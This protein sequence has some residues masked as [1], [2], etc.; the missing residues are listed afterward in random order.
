MTGEPEGRF[1]PRVPP[2]TGL[3][4]RDPSSPKFPRS[5]A[6]KLAGLG[7]T[8]VLVAAAVIVLTQPSGSPPPSGCDLCGGG[9]AIGNPNLGV[10]GVG[11]FGHL[12]GCSSGDY[13]YTLTVESSQVTF[14]S[15]TFRTLTSAGTV[16]STPNGTPGF[17]ILNTS[18]S[19]VAQWTSTNGSMFMSA[20]GWTY[21]AGVSSSTPLTNLYSV[22]IDMGKADPMGQ[23]YTCVMV[24]VGAYSGTT[25]PLALP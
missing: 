20:V 23:G 7:V 17:A 3:G 14:G 24:G 12:S 22:V 5:L 15:V 2:P 11:G 25:S 18:G 8:A 16:Y 4:A 9:T 21:S 10:C 13:A 6:L 19:V 1:G